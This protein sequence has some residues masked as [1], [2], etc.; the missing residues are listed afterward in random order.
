MKEK[1]LDYPQQEVSHQRLAGFRLRAGAFV[2]DFVL[3]FLVHMAISPY[4]SPYLGWHF[5][6]K[7]FGLQFTA[8]YFLLSI[9]YYTLLES[10]ARQATLGKMVVGLKVGDSQGHRI[11]LPNS[12]GR[13]LAA[14]LSTVP[15]YIGYFMVI[16]TTRKQAL[17]DKLAGTTVFIVAPSG[18]APS[19]QR[20]NVPGPAEAQS[21]QSL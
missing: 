6:L 10:S 2:I 4:L 3:L 21:N 14:Y 12:L 17:H 9:P 11:S 19:L 7:L 5:D 20:A 15:L 8:P 13:C 1:I 18:N 16:W